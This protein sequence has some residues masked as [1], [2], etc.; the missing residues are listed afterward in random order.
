MH[1][2][3]D[4]QR[5]FAAA[6]LDADRPAPPGLVGPDGEPSARR[7]AVYRNNVVVSLIEALKDAFPAVLRIVGEDFFR[8]MARAYAVREPPTSPILLDYG[9]GF[10]DFVVGFEP[11]AELPYLRDVA[12]IERAWR[13]AYHAGEA[14]PLGPAAFVAIAPDE[15]PRLRLVLHPSLHLVRSR[16]PAVTIWR[17]N[18]DDGVPAPV[19]LDAGG[20]D[21]LIVRPQA[22][23]EVRHVPEGGA[24][25][26]E[27][28]ANGLSVVAAAE[29]AIDAD[30]RF[31]LSVNLS[32]LL[33][34]GGFIGFRLA[35]EGRSCK[36]ARRP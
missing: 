29:T 6:L 35:V 18:V 16:Y 11:A 36:P 31:N 28:L 33:Q 15:L 1:R 8:A 30:S 22:E 10:P 32:G 21:A 14:E 7:F 23:V 19:D 3:A 5:D 25:F 2:L 24:E 4:R 13:E 17:M 34:A 12:R 27:A 9:A 20:E 26:I